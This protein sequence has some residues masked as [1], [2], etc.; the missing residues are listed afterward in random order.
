M[1]ALT[2]LL[3]APTAD[4][5]CP[6]S[7]T[8]TITPDT[9]L[10]M[11]RAEL[12]A[13]YGAGA[14]PAELQGDTRG[15]AI[16]DPGSA[17]TVRKSK[18]IGLMWKGKAFPGD[19]TM[20]N[21]LPLGLR[22]VKARVFPGESWLDGGLALVFDYCGTSKLFPHVRDEVREVAPG[23]YL[24]LT[25]LRRPTGPELAMFFVLDARGQ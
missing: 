22:A 6:C 5:G 3:L 17:G 4:A 9:L 23:V 2:L 19:G 25:Y 15:K 14:M 12:L 18:L 1:L 10:R 21:R 24:G 8:S 7:A 11:S 13:L 20:V 16:P